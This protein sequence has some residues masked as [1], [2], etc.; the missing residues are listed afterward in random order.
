[1][2]CWADVRSRAEH[3][4]RSLEILERFFPWEAARCREVELTDANGVLTGRL[5]PTVRNPIGMLPSGR[6]VLGMADAVVLND[7][8]TGQASNNAA[9]CA[10][11]YLAAL[12]EQGDGY[13]ERFESF[14]G[15]PLV[16][17]S[18]AYRVASRHPELDVR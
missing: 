8:I 4:A 9:K 18:G 11:I 5:T 16:F 12:L 17:H 3:L 6:P 14:P 1:M 10:E 13:D 15:E 2:D 7:P